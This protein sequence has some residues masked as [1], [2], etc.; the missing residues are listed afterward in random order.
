M[1]LLVMAFLYPDILAVKHETKA[2]I[3]KVERLRRNL[4]RG[5]RD[6]KPDSFNDNPVFDRVRKPLPILLSRP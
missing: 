3:E 6:K 4:E 1:I 2:Q 5:K